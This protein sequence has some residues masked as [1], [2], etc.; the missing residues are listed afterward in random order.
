MFP[1]AMARSI[2]SAVSRWPQAPNLT[3]SARFASGYSARAHPRNS[4]PSMSGIHWSASTRA[5]RSPA[6]RQPSSRASASVADPT[7]RTR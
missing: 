6:S 1:R 5:T 2:A 7:H 3:S 4:S